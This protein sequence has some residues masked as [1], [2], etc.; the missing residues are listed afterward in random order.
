LLAPSLAQQVTTSF[1]SGGSYGYRGERTDVEQGVTEATSTFDFYN[2]LIEED[3]SGPRSSWDTGHPFSTSKQFIM[4]LPM[5]YHSNVGT[6]GVSYAYN[7]PVSIAISQLVHSEGFIPVPAFSSGTYGTRAV[8]ATLP[9]NPVASLTRAI[10]ELKKDG[11][12]HLPFGLAGTLSAGKMPLFNLGEEF[13]NWKFAFQPT[14]QDMARIAYS[15]TQIHK[16]CKQLRRDS[17][18][19]VRRSFTFPPEVDTTVYP[20]KS[21]QISVFAGTP[22]VKPFVNSL[23]F[24]GGPP[25]AVATG[26]LRESVSTTRQIRFT[27]AYVFHL[28][29][30]NGIL[31]RIDR[32]AIEIQH[33]LGYQYDLETLWQLLPYSWFVDWH[34]NVSSLIHNL[35]SKATDLQVLKYGY[36]TCET[37]VRHEVSISGP[38]LVNGREGPWTTTFVTHKKERIQ[39]NPYGFGPLGSL[40]ESQWTIL[41]AL[42]L[43]KAPHV[44]H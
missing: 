23:Q 12:P 16:L 33:V 22:Q 43:A 4:D 7:G 27:G 20:E 29:D 9:L 34:F 37:V 30:S 10:L 11:L 32:D 38:R 8:A 26:T 36:L 14:A 40:S 42:G 1:R 3:R 15:I 5:V 28:P 35:M 19:L 44:L 21:G 18:R 6:D 25:V 24:G 41:G 2:R 39:A 31:D 17:G 13:L